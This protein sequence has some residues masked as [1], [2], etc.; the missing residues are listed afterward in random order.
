MNGENLIKLLQKLNGIRFGKQCRK[1]S[2]RKEIK[3]FSKRSGNVFTLLLSARK[4]KETA[5]DI[6]LHISEEQN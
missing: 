5:N 1:Y 2:L 6:N 3:N 4:K